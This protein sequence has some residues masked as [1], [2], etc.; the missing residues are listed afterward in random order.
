MP[1][2]RAMAVALFLSFGAWPA[3]A[4]T[5]IPV[6]FLASPGIDLVPILRAAR[7]NG[8]RL[9][10]RDIAPTLS[11]SNKLAVAYE[12]TATHDVDAWLVTASEL[13]AV[14]T[15]TPGSSIPALI[16]AAGPVLFIH[17][18]VRD[19]RGTSQGC[20]VPVAD[21]Q[22]LRG[23]GAEFMTTTD[24]SARAAA[25]ITT[26]TP[27]LGPDCITG[28]R[29]K[30]VGGPQFEEAFSEFL[31][32]TQPP[33]PTWPRTVIYV[34]AEGV[35][36]GGSASYENP[37]VAHLAALPGVGFLDLASIGGAL[38]AYGYVI[39]TIPARTYTEVQPPVRTA[40]DIYTATVVGA[41][42]EIRPSLK[43]F[44]KALV[45]PPTSLLPTESLRRAALRQL[46]S[47]TETGHGRLGLD[48][49]LKDLLTK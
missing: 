34:A 21:I 1:L 3:G 11:A 23:S 9:E 4:Q 7:D 27:N 20:R 49:A 41:G 31:A 13:Q 32:P 17:A 28:V 36:Y 38:K 10:I 33:T 24:P 22:C 15:D 6:V 47:L 16:E 5:Q 40:Q 18:L 39:N 12:R 30:E 14:I 48:P 44:M 2:T 26:A 43:A 42:A 25:A 19:S 45:A 37:S 46:I 8:V 35:L 29:C